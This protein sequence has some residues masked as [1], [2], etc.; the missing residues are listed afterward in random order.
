MIQPI[1]SYH[2]SVYAVEVADVQQFRTAVNDKLNS[3]RRTFGWATHSG[4]ILHYRNSSRV[5]KSGMKNNI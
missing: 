1:C 4:T 2:Y 5:P 3:L